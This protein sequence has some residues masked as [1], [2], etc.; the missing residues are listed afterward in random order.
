MTSTYCKSRS[1]STSSYEPSSPTRQPFEFAPIYISISPLGG[2][3]APSL[4][5]SVDALRLRFDLDD[6]LVL[7]LD[8]H[9]HF[10]EHLGQL[11]QG[12]F[13]LLD[14]RVSFLHL[15]IGATGRTIAVRVEQLD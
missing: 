14:F 12:L 2:T 15:A 9:G 3:D 8:E 11:G 4:D 1:R 7:L 5:V 10:R 13:D 6:C